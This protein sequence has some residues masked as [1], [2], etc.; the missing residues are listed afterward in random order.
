[1][2]NETIS[3]LQ[4]LPGGENFYNPYILALFIVFASVIT[5]Q[6]L[7]L[8][9]N[10]YIKRIAKKTKTKFDDILFASVKQPIFILVILFG[11]KL[12]LMVLGVGGIVAILVKSALAITF[13]YFLVRISDVV[14]ETWGEAVAKKTSTQIDEVLLPFLRKIVKVLFV[15]IGIIWMLHIWGIDIT[16]Y[17]AGV[18]ISGIILGLALQDSLKNI[19]GGISL[20]LDKTYQVGDK[21]ALESGEI[22][23]ITDIGLRSTKMVTFDNEVIYVPNG[24]MAN[25][26]VRNYTRPDPKVRVRVEFSV[27]YGT[28]VEKVK[29]VVLETVKGMDKVLDKPAPAVQFMS[30]GDFALKFRAVFWVPHWDNEF[31]KKV[32]ATQKIY[33][34]LNVAKIAIPFPTQTVFVKNRK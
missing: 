12:A 33:D 26:R 29:K 17:L 31:P 13:L 5:A 6:V 30:M 11:V 27:E 14:I 2:F 22:G 25:S 28:D 4:S 18:G 7:L 34:A 19:F 21:V 16:P 23:T 24:Y 20:L 9:S 15:I 1:M 10:L 8:I 3:M 32:E